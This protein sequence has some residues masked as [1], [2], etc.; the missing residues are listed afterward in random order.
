MARDGYTPAELKLVYR[1]TVDAQPSTVAVVGDD[2]IAN[3]V[4]MAVPSAKIVRNAE[5]AVDFMIIGRNYEKKCPLSDTFPRWHRVLAFGDD[6]AKDIPSTMQSGH[7]FRGCGKCFAV[8]R[9]DLP[10]EIFELKF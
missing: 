6:P 1:L 3:V 7:I 10:F 9:A 2:V 4:A 8:G 5:N